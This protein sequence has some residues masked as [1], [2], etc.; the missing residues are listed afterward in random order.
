MG[1]G[2]YVVRRNSLC[3]SGDVKSQMTTSGPEEE[4]LSVPVVKGDFNALPQEAK[5]F[6]AENVST[7]NLLFLMQPCSKKRTV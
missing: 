5:T 3:E 6:I 4:A 7:K 1:K 2:K